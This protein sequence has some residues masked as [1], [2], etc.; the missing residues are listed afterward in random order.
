[1]AKKFY[2]NSML[3]NMSV[4]LNSVF[5]LYFILLLALS[6]LFYLVSSANYMFAS[7]FIITGFLTSF[8]SKN[9]IVILCIALTVTNLLQFG[10]NASRMNEGFADKDEED[11][12]DA[13]P[14][15]KNKSS[16]G[17]A[18]DEEDEEDTPPTKKVSKN[19]SPEQFDSI[20]SDYKELLG[21]Q[22]KITDN[23]STLNDSLTKSENIL[24]NLAKTINVDINI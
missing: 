9:M 12:E 6:N 4:V 19:T 11:E 15:K 18:G 2:G 7:I 24:K 17:F 10:K 13:P 22:D 5:V 14:S 16:E 23:M 20:S 21:M 8:F 1:M 3:S